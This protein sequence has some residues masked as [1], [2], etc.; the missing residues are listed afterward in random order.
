MLA[1]MF[2]DGTPADVLAVIALCLSFLFLETLILLPDGLQ[3]MWL[4]LALVMKH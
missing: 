4:S 1:Y 2:I 3:S